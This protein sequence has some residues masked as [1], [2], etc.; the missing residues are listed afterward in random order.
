[1]RFQKT[2]E[3]LDIDLNSYYNDPTSYWDTAVSSTVNNPFGSYPVSGKLSDL[4]T[5]D[6]P[7]KLD[8]AFID[9]LHKAKYALDQ[10]VWAQLLQNFNINTYS[11]CIRYFGLSETNME[12]IAANY[13]SFFP[14][15]WNSWSYHQK[16]DVDGEDAS[17]YEQINH[18][19]GNIATNSSNGHLSKNACHYLFI[20]SYDNVVINTNGLFHRNFIFNN[21]SNINRSTYIFCASP[22]SDT[23]DYANDCDHIFVRYMSRAC[24]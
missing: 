8:S 2:S 18:N 15:F 13:Y 11:P 22:P 21:L 14:S 7:S 16:P 1:M 6:F 23:N 9:Y 20:D 10:E 5:I 12:N 3:Q 4:A 19:I 24:L 17:Y